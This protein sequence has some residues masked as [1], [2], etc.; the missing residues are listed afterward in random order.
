M[1][2]LITKYSE[3]VMPQDANV[4]GT[5]FGGQMVSWMDIAAAKS[6]HRFLKE[7]E[8]EAA[9]TRAIDAI[10][11]KEPVYVGNWVNFVSEI[12]KV[13]KSSI[14]IKVEAYKENN[15]DLPVLACKARF[16]MVSVKKSKEGIFKKINHNKKIG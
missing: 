7:T 10:E 16:T 11:F 1:K 15:K 9:L 5:L 12:I 8:A 4:V 13:G 3:L 6:V 14:V 2:N